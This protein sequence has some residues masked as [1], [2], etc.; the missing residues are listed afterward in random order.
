M[1]GLTSWIKDDDFAEL[2]TGGI[3]APVMFCARETELEAL[4]MDFP[5]FPLYCAG[6]PCR[7]KPQ[8]RLLFRERL[9]FIQP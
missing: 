9:P 8:V 2:G 3:K 7:G 4:E 5:E 1:K 6:A